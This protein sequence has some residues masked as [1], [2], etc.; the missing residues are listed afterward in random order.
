ME[1]KNKSKYTYIISIVILAFM[2]FVFGFVSW[3]NAILIPYFKIG[4]E[5]NNFQAYLVTFA[6]YIAYFV[7]SVP[8]GI[9]LKRVGFKKGIMCG[10]FSLAL[11]ALFF[12]PAAYTRTYWVFLVGLFIMGTGLAILQTAA[13]PYVTIVT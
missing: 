2:F 10:F 8:G 6:F 1:N 12:V 3:I 11:G 9:L 4:C 13:N 7:M 5:L